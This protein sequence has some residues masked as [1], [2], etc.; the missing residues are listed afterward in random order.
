MG[1]RTNAKNRVTCCEHHEYRGTWTYLG[2]YISMNVVHAQH[3]SWNDWNVLDIL[4][5]RF[6]APYLKA[7]IKILPRNTNCDRKSNICILDRAA[8]KSC[9]SFRL[10]FEYCQLKSF[11]LCQLKSHLL[12]IMPPTCLANTDPFTSALPQKNPF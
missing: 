12:M 6:N 4:R 5:P 11:F 8:K 9:L 7:I 1:K 10:H 3:V 2:L